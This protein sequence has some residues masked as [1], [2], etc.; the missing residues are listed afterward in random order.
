MSP[1][2]FD[3]F[4]D[5]NPAGP[6]LLS[7]VRED[8]RSLGVLAMSYA[9]AEVE[10]DEQLV[11][12]AVA[13]VTHPEARGRG[14]FGTLELDNEERAAADGGDDGARVHEPDGGADPRRQARLARPLPHAPLGA[15]AARCAA[16]APAGSRRAAAATSSRSTRGTRSS[17]A[18]R[19]TATRSCAAPSTSPGAT[20]TRRATTGCSAT[21]AGSRSSATRCGRASRPASSASSSARRTGSCAAACASR[22]A[23]TSCSGCRA[24]ASAAPISRPASCPRRARSA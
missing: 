5:R 10:G 21:S 16:R 2:E 12:F 24:R 4:F 22:R 7:E 8:G 11:A 6:R 15:A 18:R 14:I 9:R 19:A 1:E 17:G 20:S 13:A 23:A 3:W